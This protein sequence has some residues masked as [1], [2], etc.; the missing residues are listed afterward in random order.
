MRRFTLFSTAFIFLSSCNLN[1][2]KR[3]ILVK[4]YGS[5][6]DAQGCNLVAGYLWSNMH[7]ACIPILK[8][9]ITLKPKTVNEVNQGFPAF[10]LFNKDKS[11]AELFLPN[12]KNTSIYLNVSEGSLYLY[13]N[14]MYDDLQSKLYIDNFEVYAFDPK[15]EK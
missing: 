9:G 5:E 15:A 14:Y 11:V 2:S 1:T 8:E 3:D 10:I 13:E 6:Q 12:K 7:H 4:M